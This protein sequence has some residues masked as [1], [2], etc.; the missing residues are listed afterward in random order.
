MDRDK[1]MADIR[2]N[3]SQRTKEYDVWIRKVIPRYDEMLDALISCITVNEGTKPRAIDLGCGTGALSERLL[4]VHPD[5]ELTCL[6]MTESM[7]QLAKERMSGRGN[8]RYMLSDLYDF[9]FDGPYDVVISA[10][11][12]HHLVTDEDKKM[13]YRK[14]FDALARGGSFYNGDVVLAS[15]DEMQRRYMRIWTEFMYQGL[16]R[17][18]VDSVVLPRHYSEDSPAKLIDHLRWMNE[19]GYLSVDVVWKHFGYVVYGGRKG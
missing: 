1:R 8:V 7:L 3:F 2:S 14:I 6:D 18:E 16:P 11:A 4:N 5:M 15:D 9:E 12:L 10:L 17:E 13:V 19:V